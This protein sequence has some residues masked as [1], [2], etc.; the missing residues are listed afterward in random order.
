LPAAAQVIDG[1]IVTGKQLTTQNRDSNKR[2]AESAS[3]RV[4]SIEPTMQ[5]LLPP[6]ASPSFSFSA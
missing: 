3:H 5:Q 1:D 2:Y 6:V 4:I